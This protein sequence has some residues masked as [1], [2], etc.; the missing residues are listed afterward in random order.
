M[1]LYRNAIGLIENA[2]D[3][4]VK[5]YLDSLL[6]SK[7]ISLIEEAEE[8]RP[9]KK[10]A[11]A[12]EEGDKDDITLDPEFQKEF[13]LNTFEYKDKVITLKKVGMGASAPVSA[14]VD[15]KRKDIFLTLKQARKG[16]KKIIDMEEKRKEPVKESF[17]NATISELETIDES[18]ASVVFADDSIAF[19]SQKNANFILETYKSLNK[20]NRD[21]FEDKLKS[22]SEEAIQMVNFFQE[23]IK[24]DII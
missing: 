4:I 17:V 23:R 9:E 10:E 14:Y 7:T 18:G 3:Q 5:T 12:S 6:A 15:G 24:R 21:K 1:D 20:K 2:P 22:S 19:L 11:E 13:F 16:I 8:S